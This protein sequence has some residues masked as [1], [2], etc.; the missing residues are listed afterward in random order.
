MLG[1]VLR[2]IFRHRSFPRRE[3]V[4]ERMMEVLCHF[5]NFQVDSVKLES[6]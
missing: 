1:G 2:I 6:E 4:L 3:N 5:D